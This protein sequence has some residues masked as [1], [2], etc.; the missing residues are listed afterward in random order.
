MGQKRIQI[1]REI[2]KNVMDDMSTG[3]VGL[4]STRMDMLD[5]QKASG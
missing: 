1:Y 5:D 4:Q 2:N 3:S